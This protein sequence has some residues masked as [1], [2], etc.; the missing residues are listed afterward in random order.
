[1]AQ[2]PGVDLLFADEDWLDAEGRR[3]RPFF[4]PGWSAELQ[5]GCD[6]VGPFAF[7]RTELVRAA[8]VAAGPAWRYDLANQVAAASRAER[9][10]H[11]PAVLCHRSALPPGHAEAMR[12]AAAAQLVRDRVAAQ[13]E[14]VPGRP[15]WLRTRYALP[16][17]EPLVSRHRPDPRP[18][19]PAPGVCRR[20]AE[21]HRVSGARIAA[22]R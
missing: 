9:I 7:Y 14:P 16:R 10:R 8:T 11:I 13:V 21:P 15:G 1:M 3:E 19:R 4:K 12:R 18:R 22:G 5:R 17:P 2:Y 6:L 20:R